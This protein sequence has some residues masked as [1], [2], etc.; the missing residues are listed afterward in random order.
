MVRAA[1]SLTRDTTPKQLA[2]IL[3]TSYAKIRFFYY[4]QSISSYYEDFE[5]PKKSGG[6][7]RIDAP[8]PQLKA[9]QQKICGILNELYAPRKPAKAF[10]KGLSLVDNAKPHVRKNFV[11]NID[12]EDFF[13]SITFP[14]IRGLLMSEPYGLQASTASVIAHLCTLNGA[15]PQGSPASPVLSNMICSG[16][17]RE[18]MTLSRRWGCSYTRFADDLTF[19]F[20]GPAECLP[21]DIVVLDKSCWHFSYKE[22]DVG[23]AVRSIIA[24]NGFSI[25]EKKVRLQPKS[26]KQV[27]T[28]LTVNKKVNV[29]RAY[30]R[31]TRTMIHSIERYGPEAASDF[32][33]R[34]RDDD[35]FDLFSHIHGRML[36]IKQIKGEDSP[37]YVRLAKRFNALPIKQSLPIRDSK[38]S[39]GDYHFGNYMNKVVWVLEGYDR[40][41]LPIIQGSAF[42][43]STG[44]LITCAHLFH[45]GGAVDRCFAYRA[46]E[47]KQY[48]VVLAKKVN[49]K[50]LA[51]LSF[52]DESP[53][54]QNHIDISTLRD[55]DV[56]ERVSVWGF[57]NKKES[58]VGVS[59]FSTSVTGFCRIFE[60]EMAEIDKDIYD[61]N[62]GGPVLDQNRKLAGVVARGADT[63]QDHNAFILSSELAFFLEI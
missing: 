56:E 54:D 53:K 27:V 34:K 42:M 12:L 14:R 11:L 40:D 16:L 30:V 21:D 3:G 43:V 7:R 44:E 13:P 58:S 28:G 57:P 37:V 50:D 35:G 33:K 45:K 38:K 32:G 9:L 8:L 41:G 46:G 2:N 59:R 10:I 4:M 1:S 47:N 60:T 61:G 51:A 55:P 49:K 23:E 39:A 22:A 17:D 19:S 20:L 48:E 18:L 62:S 36:F 63:K 6:M 25:N 29:D 5:I 52:K 26:K 24:R 15:L 31:T